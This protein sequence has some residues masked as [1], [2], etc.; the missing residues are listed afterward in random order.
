MF[1]NSYGGYLA[2]L[3]AK[4][5]PWSIDF[6]LDNSSFVNLFGNIFRL[7]GFGKEIDFT[8]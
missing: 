2:N 7:I 5:A 8:R 1:G 3:C 6:I 4:I